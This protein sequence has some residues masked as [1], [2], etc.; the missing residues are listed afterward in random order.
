MKTIPHSRTSVKMPPKSKPWKVVD[1]HRKAVEV[2][3]VEEDDEVEKKPKKGKKPLKSKPRK[4]VDDGDDEEES[5]TICCSP[6]TAISPKV[7]CPF[8]KYEMCR[9]CIEKYI[10]STVVDECPACKKPFSF[11]HLQTLVSP[12]FLQKAYFK[13]RTETLINEE[14][15]L[16]PDTQDILT[17]KERIQKEQIQANICRGEYEYHK[18]NV[19]RLKHE[20]KAGIAQPIKKIPL[21]CPNDECRGFLD[22][23]H[24]ELCDKW[25]CRKCMTCVGSQKRLKKHRKRGCDPDA[26]ATV[27]EIRQNSKPCPGCAA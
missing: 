13:H 27:Q 11:Q 8:C 21:K 15:S 3:D 9:G 17:K 25:S 16:L 22:R 1:I 14:K 26:L 20:Y 23:S 6:Y 2:S 4:A 18:D 5:C 7:D 24:C 12:A 10:Q 19:R